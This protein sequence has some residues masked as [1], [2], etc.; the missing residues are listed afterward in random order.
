MPGMGPNSYS[1]TNPLVTSLFKHSAF[2]TDG[3][4]IIGI[5]FIVMVIGVATRRVLVFNLS[6]LG[7]AEPR[8]RTYLRVAFGV[9]WVVD[10][11]LQFQ[12]SM[13][14][15]LGNLV[16]APAADG[17]PSWLHRLITHGVVIW[18][19]HPIALADG[20]AWIQVG[21]GILLV[22]SNAKVGRAA[23]AVSVGWA[24][25]IWLVGN[26]AGGFFTPGNNFL[27]G[28]PGATFFYVIAGV[29]LAL[30]PRYFPERFSRVTLR[31][32]SVV[33]AGA[34]VYQVLPSRGFWRGGNANALTKMS[35]SMTSLAQPHWLSDVVRQVGVLAGTMG[36]G[37]NIVIILWLGACA[38]GL[39][40]ASDRGWRWPIWMVVAG[41]VYFWITVQDAAIFGGLAT[42]LNS[43]VPLALLTL[44]ASPQWVARE[45]LRRRLP[46]ELRA[47][48]G[49][50]LVSFATGMVAFAVISM[51]LTTFAAA[52]TTLYLAQ[53]GSA[54]ATNTAAPGFT[55]T[56]QNRA[57]YT[58]GEHQGHYTVVTFLDP[59]C[60]TDCPLLAA[61]LKS[62]SENFGPAA[63]LDL[64]A[65]AANPLHETV[66]NVRHFLQLHALA[67]VKNFYFVT[68]SLKSLTRVWDQYGIQVIS[69]PKATM[70][71]HSDLMFVI[72]PEGRIKWIVPDDPINATSLLS[73]Q[74]SAVSELT[75][76]LH[77]AGLH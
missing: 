19:S 9:M 8:S 61:Q 73:S 30:D 50:V 46:R 32:L 40:M 47:S 62:V 70:S 37:Y 16:V 38:V 49:A 74:S 45:P 72:D 67:R 7:L 60:Y 41:C 28:W 35:T 39:W 3:M 54:S 10:G 42:D 71:V 20:A 66:A 58:L 43:L 51:S 59:V 15:G 24:A 69:S 53:N 17:T 76:L 5:A 2:V 29:W 12:V 77:A 6:D 1:I 55:L 33:F 48:T 56:D 65:V 63:P 18:N 27:F 34:I 52:E 22:S 31:I 13:P 44:C 75:S 14:L 25:L 36:G 26:G 64:V 23:A 11:L 68:G 21:V 4:W 57:P